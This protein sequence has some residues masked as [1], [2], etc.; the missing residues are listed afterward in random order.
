MTEHRKIFEFF[1]LNLK[2]IKPR[3]I[4]NFREMGFSKHFW[5]KLA[6][7]FMVNLIGV[8]AKNRAFPECKFVGWKNNSNFSV[9]R[10]I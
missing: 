9:G 1:V 2:D 7:L 3:S 6:M 5:I 10:R 4:F 8:Q